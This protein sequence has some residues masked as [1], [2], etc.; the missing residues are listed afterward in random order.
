M[1]DNVRAMFVGQDEVEAQD[2][3]NAKMRHYREQ[4]A[5]ALNILFGMLVFV[6]C[7]LVLVGGFAAA[8]LIIR[9]VF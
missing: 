8:V 4:R 9:S 6:L 7:V 5:N 1:S 3:H 2:A